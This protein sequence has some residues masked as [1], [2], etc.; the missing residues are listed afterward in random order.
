MAYAYVQSAVGTKLQSGSNPAVTITGVTAGNLLVLVMPYTSQ[1]RS[2]TSI[3][4]DKSNT[5]AIG[6]ARA[7]ADSSSCEMWYAM[8][9]AA[10]NTVVTVTMDAGTAANESPVVLEY[11]GIVTSGAVEGTP[12]SLGIPTGASP[13]T[14]AAITTTVNGCLLLGSVF[15]QTPARPPS[16][17]SG[18]TTRLDETGM[19]TALRVMD[20]RQTTA[21]AVTFEGSWTGG[22]ATGVLNFMAF[23]ESVTGPTIDTQPS[24]DTALVV[25]VTTAVFTTAATTSGGALTYQWQKEDSVGAG[26][27]SNISN[28]SVY[29]GVT[30][31]SLTITIADET[32][33]GLKYRCNVTDN[34]GTTATSGATLSA[35]T[36]YT[37]TQ[38][39]TLT[40][41]SGQ[42]TG[43]G[44]TDYTCANGE[45]FRLK[46]TH[47]SGTIAYKHV[48]GV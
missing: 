11:S 22:N 15:I 35:Y 41:S 39:T 1:N 33:H 16:Q 43:T 20:L 18:Y 7:D 47:S 37:V 19:A 10:G 21:A 2:I 44:V 14:T 29:A 42:V 36:G 38:T 9:V 27:Y 3:A 30:T 34:N 5:W 28:S 32:L 13:G 46:M 8:N 48:R 26:T 12:V 4:D 25:P 24:A 6:P 17:T 45:A 40:D 31:A 23:E